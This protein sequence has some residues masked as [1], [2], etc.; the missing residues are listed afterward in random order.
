MN[1]VTAK[2]DS[3]TERYASNVF[4]DNAMRTYLPGDTYKQL[5]KTISDGRS[6]DPSIADAVANGMKR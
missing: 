1:V 2:G 3:L 5:R 4:D 6:L